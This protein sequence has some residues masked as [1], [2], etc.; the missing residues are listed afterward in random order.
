MEEKIIF[1]THELDISM[2]QLVYCMCELE[3]KREGRAQNPNE[4][5]TL[6]F[7]V[8]AE[9]ARDELFRVLKEISENKWNDINGD[10]EFEVCIKR[11]ELAPT[12]KEVG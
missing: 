3:A 2:K 7:D 10:Y 1:R 12:G 8:S 11:I 9:L 6:S 4:T 5:V